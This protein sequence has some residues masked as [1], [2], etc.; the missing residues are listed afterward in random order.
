MR[1]LR[2]SGQKDY[3][4]VDVINEKEEILETLFYLKRGETKKISYK[5]QE[6]GGWIKVNVKISDDFTKIKCKDIDANSDFTGM[7]W[8]SD[9]DEL[10]DL[11]QIRFI[12]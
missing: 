9:M 6:G 4:A 2:V 8:D 5:D 7:E 11:E 3:I 10:L 1:K 12:K